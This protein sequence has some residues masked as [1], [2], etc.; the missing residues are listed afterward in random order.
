VIRGLRFALEA[1]VFGALAFPRLIRDSV[2][3][4]VNYEGL[5]HLRAAV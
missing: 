4:V 1:A 2:G 3:S 5:A